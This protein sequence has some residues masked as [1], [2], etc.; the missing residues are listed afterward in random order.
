[1]ICFHTLGLNVIFKLLQIFFCTEKGAI[2]NRLLSK[3]IY[4][5][6]SPARL[7]KIV[8]SP[9]TP[10]FL[11]LSDEFRNEY[12]T[13]VFA[14]FHKTSRCIFCSSKHLFFKWYA[15]VNISILV[16]KWR[17]A[18][19]SLNEVC[20]TSKIMLKC[21]G[22]GYDESLVTRVDDRTLCTPA[23]RVCQPLAELATRAEQSDLWHISAFS[24]C[25]TDHSAH[26]RAPEDGGHANTV[27]ALCKAAF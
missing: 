15:S 11:N 4:W 9:P 12:N 21:Y 16:G 22:R 2:H 19:T 3:I 24:S 27:C 14:D 6:P 10:F 7:Q 26:T 23:T 13:C 5:I 17:V 25:L 8:L 1:M 20:W 18:R